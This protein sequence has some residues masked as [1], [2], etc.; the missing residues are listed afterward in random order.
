MKERGSGNERRRDR[1]ERERLMGVVG[2]VSGLVK[3]LA[4]RDNVFKSVCFLTVVQSL[5]RGH[6]VSENNQV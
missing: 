6:R 4:E 1:G 2:V 5:L 3:G